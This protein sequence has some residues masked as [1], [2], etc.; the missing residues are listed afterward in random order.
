MLSPG[1]ENAKVKTENSWGKGKGRQIHGYRGCRL[2][3][4]PWPMQ[5]YQIIRITKTVPYIK[6]T[7]SVIYTDL[8]SWNKVQTLV[9]TRYWVLGTQ[10]FLM[11]LKQRKYVET[12]PPLLSR[13]PFY[14]LRVF[15]HIALWGSML[16]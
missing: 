7:E 4:G 14:G 6:P 15:I 13:V 16:L 10:V 11:I 8:S 1:G 5:F 12:E 2:S 9:G 3:L